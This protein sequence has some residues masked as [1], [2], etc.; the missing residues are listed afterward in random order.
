MRTKAIFMALFLI[1]SISISF[2]QKTNDKGEFLV[3]RIDVNYPD[4]DNLDYSLIF[5]Y[6]ESG[7]ITM[8]EHFYPSTRDV[9]EFGVDFQG[10]KEVKYKEVFYKKEDGM[11]YKKAT[12]KEKHYS[13]NKQGTLFKKFIYFNTIKERIQYT[14]LYD[15]SWKHVSTFEKIIESENDPKVNSKRNGTLDW[16][17]K[18]N[19]LNGYASTVQLNDGSKPFK[20][21]EEYVYYQSKNVSNIDFN[22]LFYLG[23]LY[24]NIEGCIGLLGEKMP[25]LFAYEKKKK[26][27]FGSIVKY[28]YDDLHRVVLARYMKEKILPIKNVDKVYKLLY[29]FYTVKVQYY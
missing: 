15:K 12:E 14:F 16:S 4:N 19:C 5:H 23:D 11:Y 7:N 18:I 29:T 2:C 26:E 13:F 9:Y 24:G 21:K 1:T 8:M 17:R 6:D 20:I 22:W 27:M 28:E 10:L 3:R 25:Y